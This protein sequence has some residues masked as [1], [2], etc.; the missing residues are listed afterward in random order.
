MIPTPARK[1]SLLELLRRLHKR[2]ASSW[3]A[4]VLIAILAVPPGLYPATTIKCAGAVSRADDISTE[5]KRYEATHLSMGTEF[6]VAAYGRDVKLLAETVG[7][8]FEEIDRIDEQMSNYKPGSELSTINREA[9]S[10]SVQVEPSLFALLEKSLQYSQETG[11]AFDITVGPLMKAW[12]FFRGQGRVPSSEELHAVLAHIGYQHVRLDAVHRTIRFDTPGVELDLGGIAKG[13]AV[14][15]A[16]AILR[17]NGVTAALVSSGMS[18]IYALGAPPEE[19]GWKIV[20]RNPFDSTVPADVVY[21]KNFSMSTSGNYNKFFKLGGKTYSH[22]MDPHTG[23][24]VENMLSATVFVAVATD[25]DALSKL[26]VL[27]AEGSKRYLGTHPNIQALFYLPAGSQKQ[28]KRVLIQSA[29]FN[30]PPGT[31]V[32]I[33]Q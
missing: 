17:E 2:T 7:E 19:E 16:V 14:D 27:G 5:V 15:R 3:S 20:L 6:T 25:S 1:R 18:S 26:Y 29:S 30:L 23:M 31:L 32:R 10:H 33:M 24:P 12:G 4:L 13:Y 28:F 9:A 21:L 11:G 22:I 8:A